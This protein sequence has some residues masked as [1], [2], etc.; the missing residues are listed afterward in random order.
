MSAFAH[1]GLAA[2]QQ[3]QG[4]DEDANE[5]GDGDGCGKPLAV[6]QVLIEARL[7]ERIHGNFM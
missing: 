5:G 2:C 3:Y 1:A 4:D 7:G 6:S